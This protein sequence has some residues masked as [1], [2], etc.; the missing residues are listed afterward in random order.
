MSEEEKREQRMM[1]EIAEFVFRFNAK[2]DAMLNIKIK[3]MKAKKTLK[4]EGDS[5]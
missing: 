1:E 4:K 5:E 2:Y 3:P